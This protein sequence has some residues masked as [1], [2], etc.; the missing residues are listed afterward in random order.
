M[1]KLSP[2]TQKIMSRL[3]ITCLLLVA[4]LFRVNAQNLILNPGFELGTGDNFTNWNKYNGNSLLLAATPAE[5]RTGSRALKA[6]VDGTQS[7]AG[8]PYSVQFVTDDITTTIGTSYTFK[9]YVKGSTAGTGVFRFSTQP[10]AQYSANF[11]VT[12]GYT[13]VSWTFTAN[14]AATKIVMDLGANQNTYF[15]DDAE[16]AVTATPPA[17][18]SIIPNPGFQLGAGDVFTNWTKQN[19]ASLLTAAT[20]AES[21][22]DG[23]AL[24]VNVT[25]TQANAGQPWSVQMISDDIPTTVGAS[26]TFKVYVRAATLN[27]SSNIRFSTQPS[28]LYSA[29]YAITDGYVELTWTFTANVAMTKM[30]LDLGA[31]AN[32]YFLD[33]MELLPPSTLP[34]T[35]TLMNPGFELGSGNNFNNWTKQNGASLLLESTLA[36]ARTG[37]RALKATVTGTQSNAGQPWSVQMISDSVL[38][39]IGESYTFK[40]YVKADNAGTAA[41]RFSTTPSAL[42][43][44]D[45]DV[46]TGYTQLVWTFIANTAK[47]RIVFDLGANVNTYYFDDVEFGVTTVAATSALLNPGFELGTG[48]VFT[49]WT[50]QNGV[51]LLVAASPSESHSG[52][53]ALKATITGTQ[54]NAGQP[55][56]V[57]MISDSV[58]TT[59]GS[60]YIF[61][62]YVKADAAGSGAIRFS[63]TPNAKYSGDYNVTTGYT[64][65]TWTFVANAA[66]TRIVLDLGA[67]VNNYYLDDLSLVEQVVVVPSILANGGFETG[68]PGNNFTNWG[69]WNDPSG[70]TI[71]ET[72]TTGEFKSGLRGVK[73]VVASAGNP[74]E[75]QLV[76]DPVYT[77]PGARY[78]FKVYAKAA[79]AGSTIRFSTQPNALYSEDYNVTTGFT[80]FSWTFTANSTNTRIVFDL[81]KFANT[82]YLDDATLTP[83]CS[84]PSFTPPVAQTPIATGKNKFL[85]CIYSTAQLP[86]AD[87]YF[88]QVAPENSGKWGEVEGTEGVYDFTSVDAAREYAK[89]HNF[90]FRYH[91][92]L[93]G[94]QQPTW[95]KPMNDVQKVAK[96]KAWMQAVANHYDGST[97]AKAKLE[98]IEVFN[99]TLN[100]PPNNTTNP[101]PSY[102]FPGADNTN[103][104]GSGDYVNALK[105]L[106]TELGTTAGT[107]D[108]IVN[109]FKLARQYFGCET[110]LMINDY[111]IENTPL[112]MADYTSII[113]LLKNDN[114]VDVVAMQTHTFGT[115]VYGAGLP[116]DYTANT[117]NLTANLNVL[118]AKGYPVM[119]TEFDVDGDVSLDVLGNRITTGTQADKDAFQASEYE[120]IFNVYWNHPS[121]IGITLWGYRDGHWRSGNAAYIMDPC[122]GAERPAMTFLNT[123]IRASTPSA[124]STSFNVTGVMKSKQTG[125]WSDP[126]T[127]SCGRLPSVVEDV[128]ISVGHTVNIIDANAKAKKV[129]NNGQ[130]NFSNSSAKLGL[131]E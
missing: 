12:T 77:L 104:G 89:V 120:R 75:V 121:V 96:I 38:T 48:D 101:H 84:S 90:P 9:V 47:T 33:D 55:W 2:S 6:T 28:A 91:V 5:S 36:Q 116:A 129:N 107:Y 125:N 87:K 19:G 62:A 80:Q 109:A 93:W 112:A 31:N 34:V 130:L 37:N 76:S 44:A 113:Q 117:A 88:N 23:R 95:L 111:A 45:Y 7:N 100:D 32:T 131:M 72:T 98:Y 8:Q 71:Q 70:N 58:A 22:T 35:S 67:N 124:L 25:G 17:S 78:I 85:G 10:N 65:V 97:N 60:T 86:N 123:T 99:E 83:D 118:A 59:I 52:L 41:I 68:G 40:V 92:L 73:V 18:T 94:S 20:P 30:V 26:Y 66:K 122:S 126:A 14:V 46:T 114:L 105:S 51:A 15:F 39:T 42:Y 81:G 127:W 29:D 61:S 106:N 115:Q 110:K 74:W 102:G 56:S 82:F 24:K 69:K 3:G 21:R 57:Q 79:T 16:L 119:I 54:S 43:S 103:D 1:N 13:Q 27:S 128:T 4:T 11:N 49:N 63:T 108:W 53:R 50:K 64:L